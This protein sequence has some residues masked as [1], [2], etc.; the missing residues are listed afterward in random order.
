MFRTKPTSTPPSTRSLSRTDLATATGGGVIM[1][2]INRV[3]SKIG[4]KTD[5]GGSDSCT[6]TCVTGT[7]SP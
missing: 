5:S 6:D 7:K 3:L 4:S 1:D 2:A